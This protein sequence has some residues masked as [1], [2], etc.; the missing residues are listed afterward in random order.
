MRAINQQSLRILQE[1]NGL[2]KRI[3]LLRDHGFK[4]ASVQE[5]YSMPIGHGSDGVE[6][7]Q[8]PMRDLQV[9]MNIFQHD[10]S[11]NEFAVDIAFQYELDSGD[12]GEHPWDVAAMGCGIG[13][14][15][16]SVKAMLHIHGTNH[17]L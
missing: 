11:Q 7:M 6:P 17:H 3:E 15:G 9:F 14:G 5:T 13:I 16:Y 2:Q 4:V 12:Y 8:V 10:A 1:T